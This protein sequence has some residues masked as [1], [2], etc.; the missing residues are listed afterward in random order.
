MVNGRSWTD[1]CVETDKLE[2]RLPPVVGAVG[3]L[4]Q[5]SLADVRQKQLQDPVI[6]EVLKEAID[7]QLLEIGCQIVN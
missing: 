5:W 2:G 3:I 7:L 4:P 1:T 6:G